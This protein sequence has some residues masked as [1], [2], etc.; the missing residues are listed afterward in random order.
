M[1]MHQKLF[2][3]LIAASHHLP[4]HLRM[5]VL[6][7]KYSVFRSS[8]EIKKLCKAFFILFASSL[9]HHLPG[10]TDRSLPMIILEVFFVVN[11]ET[12]MA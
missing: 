1:G 11:S 7:G 3:P 9:H 10:A 6:E 2:S 4:S 5:R 12:C 8:L